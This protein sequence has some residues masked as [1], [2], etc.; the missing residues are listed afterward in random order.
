MEIMKVG[1]LAFVDINTRVTSEQHADDAPQ[2]EGWCCGSF[3]QM[4]ADFINSILTWLRSCCGSSPL[5]K[6]ISE[7]GK[8]IEFFID[9]VKQFIV[10]KDQFAARVP[11]SMH[12][13]V[14]NFDTLNKEAFMDAIMDV[15]NEDK[16]RKLIVGSH[17]FF[18]KM[19]T[20]ETRLER[21]P[22][23]V[24]PKNQYSRSLIFQL[25]KL[26]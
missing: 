25:A 16:T 11:H 23:S 17:V 8:D 13:T 15:L 12:I 9:G 1:P 4:I 18:A 24:D 20:G 5:E 7:N 22:D 26:S 3:C 21:L 19:M 2:T 6:R 14:M 10:T